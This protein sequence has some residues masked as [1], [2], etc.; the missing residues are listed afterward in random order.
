MIITV[1]HRTFRRGRVDGLRH[2]GVSWGFPN[3]RRRSSAAVSRH[4][5]T[6]NTP[7]LAVEWL[8]VNDAS[9][10]SN[11]TYAAKQARLT[12]VEEGKNFDNGMK[13]KA[14]GDF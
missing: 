8:Y 7:K 11:K 4:A 6:H 9:V 5:L 14:S 2:Y 13:S 3:Q 10:G 1:G 12:Y